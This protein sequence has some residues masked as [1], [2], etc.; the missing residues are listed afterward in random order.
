MSI[1]KVNRRPSIRPVRGSSGERILR[2]TLCGAVAAI[3]LTLAPSTM[4]A[5][6]SDVPPPS[7]VKTI[8]AQYSKRFP[9][10]DV[11]FRAESQKSRTAVCE[12]T[13]AA[14]TVERDGRRKSFSV[15]IDVPRTGG[16]PKDVFARILR[17]TVDADGSTRAYH[18]DDPYGEGVCRTGR[19]RNGR[20][21]FEGVCALDNLSSGGFRLF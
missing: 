21:I 2:L 7:V 8:A 3:C 11:S 19:D 9:A 5:Q 16:A 20:T 1:P 15:L 12:M 6:Q 14:M 10:T 13:P 4:F 18:P 17:M